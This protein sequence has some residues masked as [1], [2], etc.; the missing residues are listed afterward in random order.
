MK[1]PIIMQMHSGEN[2]AAALAMILAYYK[3]Y[4]PMKTI[5]AKCLSS[6]NGSSLKQLYNAAIFFNL[7]AEILETGF[8]KL[9]QIKTPFIACWKRS[10]YVVIRGFKHGKVLLNDPAGGMYSVTEEKFKSVFKN[11]ILILR[12]GQAFKPEGKPVS[13]L[14]IILDRIKNL[15]KSAL[16][17]IILHSVSIL[18]GLFVVL[19]SKSMLDDV[20]SKKNLA[21]YMPIL[22]SMIVAFVFNAVFYI[23]QTLY[24]YKISRA[25]AATSSSKFL[26]KILSLPMKFYDNHYI[27]DILERFDANT[28]LDHSLLKTVSPRLADAI[29]VFIYIIFMFYYNKIIAMICLVSEFVYIIVS[30]VIQERIST[31]SHSLNSSSGALRASQLNGLSTIDTIKSTGAERSFFSMWSKSQSDFQQNNYRIL[32][33]RAISLF[34]SGWHSVITSAVLLFI[35]A[36]FIINKN[37][38]LGLMASFGSVLNNLRSNLSNCVTTMNDLSSMSANIERVDDILVRECELEIPIERDNNIDKISG[39]IN[40]ENLSYYYIEGDKLALKDINLKVK[41]GEMIALVGSTGCGKST[42]IKLIANL[43]KPTSGKITYDGRAREEISD[44][45]FFASVA[46]VDQETMLFEDSIAQ[47]LKLWDETISDKEMIL[48]SKDAEIHDRIISS[49]NGYDSFIL[50]KGSNYSA[51]EQQRLELAR[52]LAK[53]PTV[54]LLDE[55]TSSLDAI[56]EEKVFKAIKKRGITCVL[57]AHRMSTVSDCDQIIVIDHGSIIE[58]G[59]HDQLYNANGFYKKLMDK[60]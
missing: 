9:K 41:Q 10:R 60:Q 48:A 15:K 30:L 57:A 4:L 25:M 3:K 33:I 46:T 50:E 43:Y 19:L 27:G 18:M 52:A 45:A 58:H 28:T 24:A 2:G 38:T 56:T 1:V 42:L 59:T 55:F 36:F 44:A 47:N 31:I 14:R 54:L 11:K 21:L 22:V 35:G 17:I 20:I 5:R 26:K 8:D 49:S 34:F 13:V 29:M 16:I 7:E 32:K 37:F 39:V 51:G 12:P 40:I 53:N 6:R 23:A